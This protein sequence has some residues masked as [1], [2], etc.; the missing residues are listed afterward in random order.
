MASF[1]ENNFEDSLDDYFNQYFNQAFETLSMRHQEEGR[2][3]KKNGLISKDIVKKGT[4]VY[5]LTISVKRQHILKISSDDD[6]E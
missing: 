6:L 4:F 1:S 2:K 5:G 3:Q